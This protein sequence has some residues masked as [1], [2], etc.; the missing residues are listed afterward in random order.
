MGSAGVEWPPNPLLTGLGMAPADG[1]VLRVVSMPVLGHLP[2]QGS[3]SVVP[4]RVVSMPVL[5]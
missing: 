4:L 3:D 5:R 1:V 2:W